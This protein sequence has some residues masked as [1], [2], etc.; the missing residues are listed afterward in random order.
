MRK[1]ELKRETEIFLCPGQE[2]AIRTNLLKYSID[3]TSETPC[4]RLRNK[5]VEGFI[6]IISACPNLAKNQYCKKHDKVAKK[7]DWLLCKKSYLECNDKWYEH[8][9]DTVLENKRSKILW[10][11]PIQNDKI[12]KHRQLDIVCINKIVK[13]CLI[14]DIAIPGD[15]NITGKEQQQI[16]KYQDLRIE[17]G[18]L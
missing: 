2:Q 10:D 12:I 8:V 6:H 18:K 14:S 7:I 5:N 17:L 13:S 3:K 9:Y 11:F 15:Q 1:G 4:C 16:D